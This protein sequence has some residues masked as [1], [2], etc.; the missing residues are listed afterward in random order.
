MNTELMRT[1]YFLPFVTAIACA[2]PSTGFSQNADQAPIDPNNLSLRNEVGRAVSR[3]VKWLA[4]KLEKEGRWGDEEYPAL[5]ALAVRAILAEPVSE[6]RYNTQVDGGFDFILSKVQ[7]DGGI[8]GRGLASY[9]TSI[10]MMALLQAKNPEYEPII[11][12]ARK[13]LVNQ[14][15]DFDKR[16]QDDNV[17]DGGIGYGARWAHS[18]L[19]N[20]HLAMEA[21]FYSKKMLAPREAD[22]VELDWEAAINFVGR[23]QNLSKT[24][25]QKW[26]STHPDDRGGFI[27]FP[28]SSMAGERE[29]ADG[30]K[31]LRS[32]GSMS[33]AGLL[34]FIY[35]EMKPDDQRV[36]AAREWINAHYSV[37]ENPGMGEQ[38]LYYYYHTMSKALSLSGVDVIK[39]TDGSKAHWRR[40][41]AKKLFNLQRADGSWINE[42]GRW[43]ERDPVLVTAYALLT[44][45]RIYYGL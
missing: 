26:V 20:T 15:S 35:A 11:R 6:G 24:N 14:Q 5:T 21:L 22:N 7:S 30:S 39:K 28:G 38:G 18:D 34:S 44:L 10:C 27:Y 36:Q 4:S 16:G 25:D 40:D 45:E 1:K 33:Y 42:N 23:C 41:L 31:Q 17:F 13:F 32:Y 9:N 3:G 37:K 8:Y 12:K 19:S 29:S 2:V 43:W